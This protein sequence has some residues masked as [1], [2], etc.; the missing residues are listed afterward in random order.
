MLDELIFIALP[1][2]AIALAVVVTPYRYISNRLEWSTFS[3]QFIE[4]KTLFWGSIPW[5]YGVVILLIGHLIGFLFPSTIQAIL[6]NLSML[7]TLE[8]IA[9]TLGLL[10]LIGSFILLMRRALSNLESSIVDYILLFL[11]F[12]QAVTGVYIAVFNRWGME[13]YLHTA[14][15]WFYSLLTFSPNISYVS[16]LPLVFKLHVIGAFL[17]LAFLPFTKL[18]HVLFL[19]IG[20]VKDPPILY[21][22]VKRGD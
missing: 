15:P 1:Y 17:I 20:F 3:T 13:W 14:V 19:P 18:V 11:I 6:S 8:S 2:F 16:A 5:H 22:W 12:F 10:A 4:R 9:L 21:R 7:L